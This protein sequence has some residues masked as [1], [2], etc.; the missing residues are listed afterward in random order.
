MV[1]YTYSVALMNR[2]LDPDNT[3][4]SGIAGFMITDIFEN[5]KKYYV[6][7]L[8]WQQ[9]FEYLS[10]LTAETPPGDMVPILNNGS[11]AR[12]M[13]YQTL[14]PE[15]AVLEAHDKYVD[16]QMSLAGTECIDWFPRSL[17]TVKTPYDSASDAVFF[18]RPAFDPVHVINRPGFFTVLFPQDV[19]APQL[20]PGPEPGQVKKVVVK[21]PV[22]AL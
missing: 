16:I 10:A 6:G 9:T 7:N 1:Y 11:K 8:L 2:I 18:E 22:D 20:S 14:S 13:C 3:P 5:W 15:E 4:D 21:I 12:V 17:L 19:H